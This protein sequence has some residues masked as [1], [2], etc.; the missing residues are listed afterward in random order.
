MYLFVAFRP[1]QSLQTNSCP[2]L[3]CIYWSLCLVLVWIW[4]GVPVWAPLLSIEPQPK[5][6]NRLHLILNTWQQ[7]ERR[8]GERRKKK[9]LKKDK[10][11]K[12]NR[13]DL[14]ERSLLPSLSLSLTHFY[15]GSLSL[16]S[17]WTFL[18][19]RRRSCPLARLADKG[20][21]GDVDILCSFYQKLRNV[22]RLNGARNLKGYQLT[23]KHEACL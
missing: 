15:S 7:L 23:Q 1:D 8:K 2:S 4:P 12:K 19:V 5:V 18:T 11:E 6:W 20:T 22:S 14:S 10:K 3:S 17:F 13:V 21:D 9:T 16:L